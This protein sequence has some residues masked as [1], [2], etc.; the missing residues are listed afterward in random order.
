MPRLLTLGEAAQHLRISRPLLLRLL[1]R[2]EMPGRKV[3]GLWRIPEDSLHE[4]FRFEP[5]E[6][7]A[8]VR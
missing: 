4:M 1:K 7:D 5:K 6:A 3:G 2:G 8:A